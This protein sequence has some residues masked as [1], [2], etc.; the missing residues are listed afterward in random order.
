MRIGYQKCWRSRP[1]EVRKR[2]I[3]CNNLS[4]QEML[5]KTPGSLLA[6]LNCCH[7]SRTGSDLRLSMHPYSCASGIPMRHPLRWGEAMFLYFF[8]LSIHCALRPDPAQPCCPCIRNAHHELRASSVRSGSEGGEWG[9]GW[10]LRGG[11]WETL[12]PCCQGWKKSKLC[13]PVCVR[14]SA[15]RV[16]GKI[17]YDCSANCTGLNHGAK[18]A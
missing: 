18:Q 3:W 4:T 14:V 10:T 2:F 9:D 7:T 6:A 17:I 13:V 16:T 1:R 8:S 15:G 12:F 5:Q 11:Q